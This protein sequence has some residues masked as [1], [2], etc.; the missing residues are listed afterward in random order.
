MLLAAEPRAKHHN[1]R[2]GSED[3][4]IA[5]L[6]GLVF[7]NIVAEHGWLFQGGPLDTLCGLLQDTKK[8]RLDSLQ[9]LKGLTIPPEVA[10]GSRMQGAQPDKIVQ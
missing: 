7:P 4:E 5:H 2:A 10:T 3:S 1:G 9:G 8:E 6:R